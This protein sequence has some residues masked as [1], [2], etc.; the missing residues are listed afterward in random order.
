MNPYWLPKKKLLCMLSLM[1]CLLIVE[2]LTVTYAGEAQSMKQVKDMVKGDEDPAKPENP[3]PD[4]SKYKRLDRTLWYELGLAIGDAGFP[5]PAPPGQTWDCKPRPGNINLCMD[6]QVGMT[7]CQDGGT[8]TICK[9]NPCR[10]A[11]NQ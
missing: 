4:F 2:H 10:C 8:T 6:S 3:E 5:P 9:A 11:P 7:G 1:S